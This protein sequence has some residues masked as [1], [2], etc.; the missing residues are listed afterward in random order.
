MKITYTYQQHAVVECSGS[1]DVPVDIVAAGGDA[2]LDY[3]RE[4][5]PSDE[6]HRTV[7]WGSEIVGSME[8]ET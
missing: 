7:D 1:L 2:L 4:N 8:T 3:I 5:L 6:D